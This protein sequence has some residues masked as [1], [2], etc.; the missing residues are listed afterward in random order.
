MK[1]TL[2]IVFVLLLLL[3]SAGYAQLC[4]DSGDSHSK[5]VTCFLLPAEIGQ[6]FIVG[7]NS[8]ITPFT[9]SLRLSPSLGIGNYGKFQIGPTGGLIYTNPEVEFVGG[10]RAAYQLYQ[11]TAI[12]GNPVLDVFLTADFL[13]GSRGNNFLGAGISLGLTNLFD[14]GPRVT[15]NTESKLTHIETS[16]TF[17]LTF[18]MS[19]KIACSSAVPDWEPGFDPEGGFYKN[20]GL[21]ARQ[22]VLSLFYT[23]PGTK[24]KL[25]GLSRSKIL[26]LNNIS[27]VK[28]YL[29]NNGLS[30]V[31]GQMDEVI[32]RSVQDSNK[33]EQ[34]ELYQKKLILSFVNGWCKAVQL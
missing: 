8:R 18:L 31:A 28:D 24:E 30:A 6:G 3:P 15:Y 19:S 16:A 34:D 1:K 14:L 9:A 27:E 17:D 2:S 21:N 33:P 4:E 20:V 29:I 25:E 12:A 7:G 26:S 23:Q 22:L 11:L 32:K 5:T 10:A 13:F